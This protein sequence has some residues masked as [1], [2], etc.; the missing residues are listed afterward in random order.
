MIGIILI[1]CGVLI[2]MWTTF[3]VVLSFSGNAGT[4][5]G[6]MTAFLIGFIWLVIPYVVI[7]DLWWKVFSRKLK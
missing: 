5:D 3:W 2:A 4:A 1:T 7:S 6:P